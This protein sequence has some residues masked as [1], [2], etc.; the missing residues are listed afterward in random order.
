[1]RTERKTDMKKESVAFRN[2]GAAP[3]N[4]FLRIALFQLQ[5]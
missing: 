4:S 1:M 3:K 5:E 2:F